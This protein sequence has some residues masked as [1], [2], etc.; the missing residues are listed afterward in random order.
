MQEMSTLLLEFGGLDPVL[1]L[2][3]TKP[4]PEWFSE[5]IVASKTCCRGWYHV[6]LDNFFS[7]EKSMVG[8]SSGEA[9]ILHEKAEKVWEESGV[10]SSAKKKV[11]DAPVVQELGALLDGP[12]KVVGAS[13]ERLLKLTKTTLCCA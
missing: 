7:G 13:S 4:V 12:G 1:R 10:I 5:I 6:Y 11:S 2:Q 8:G 3:R 9:K